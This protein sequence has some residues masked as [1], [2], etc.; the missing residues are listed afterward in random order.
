M[1]K[2]LCHPPVPG[3]GGNAPPPGGERSRKLSIDISPR[4]VP[5]LELGDLDKKVAA[6]A[7]E[8]GS[9]QGAVGPR[10][11]QEHLQS[12][13]LQRKPGLGPGTRQEQSHPALLS[14]GHLSNQISLEVIQPA[15][16]RAAR[17]PDSQTRSQVSYGFPDKM[18][19]RP[20][21]PNVYWVL[22]KC[23]ALGAQ[24]LPVQG[25]ADQ[26][27]DLEEVTSPL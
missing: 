1:G 3:H 17:Y 20:T 9:G 21:Q 26:L 12:C 14:A 7:G 11:S 5:S 22:K 18:S 19:S 10:A 6:L 8:V 24:K 2:R 23:S 27:C 4:V 13:L 25:T 16:D 15:K